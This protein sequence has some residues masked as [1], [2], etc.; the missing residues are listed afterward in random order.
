MLKIHIE[1]WISWN[2]HFVAML[3]LYA[4]NEKL[5][6]RDTKLILALLFVIIEKT[7][8][9]YK[10]FFQRNSLKAQRILTKA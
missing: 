7:L 3:L 5:F 4:R 2:Y 9:K 6:L 10:I 8:N 1:D